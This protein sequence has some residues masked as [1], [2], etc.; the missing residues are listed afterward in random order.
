M[1][2]AQITRE[3]RFSLKIG[4]L[5]IVS[6]ILIFLVFQGGLF[7]KN[8]LFPQP[9]TPAEEKFGSLP[10]LVFPESTNSLPE[11]K[12]NTVSGNFPS[13]PSTIL[14]YKLQQ[15]T[16][17]VSDYQSARNRAASLGY[18]QNQ[19]AINQSLYKWSKSNANNVLFYDI[20]S[21]NFSVE[22]DYLTDPNLIPSPL[23]NTEDVTEAILSFI[24][25]LG[26]STSDIDLSKSPIF[27]YNISSGQ[28]VEA[29][30]AINATVARI[31]LKQQDVN[32]LPIYYPTSNPSSLY[33]TTTSDT[34]SGVVHANYNHFLPDLNDSST[35]KLR[36]AESAFE[37]LKKGKGY[38]VRP[39][40]ASTID[41]TDISLG[42]YL[43]TESSQKYLMP[44]IVFTG[45]NNFQ[46][47]LSAL[48]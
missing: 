12:L 35:Y 11:F 26:A 43:S 5:I 40:T 20:T 37:D 41:I 19:Q 42:Y 30:S 27:Y 18:T 28:L 32:E 8:F 24:H 16:P 23:S 3:A 17:K 4:G 48:P 22:S 44:I 9:P 46:A 31:F 7:I 33:I 10:T 45:A 25:T 1:S 15:K 21:L 29:E 38:I 47:Y 14:V 36:S 13:F 6:L 34:T 2:L 39:T